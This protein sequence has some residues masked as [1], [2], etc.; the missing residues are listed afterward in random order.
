MNLRTA[1]ALAAL[2]LLAIPMPAQSR[3]VTLLRNVNPG[4][5]FNDVWGYVDPAT[6][7]EYAFLL[8]RAATFIY[9][10]SDPANPILRG[11]IQGSL[12][13]WTASTWRDARTYAGYLYVVTEGGGG[14]QIIDIRNPDQPAFVKTFTLTGWR[15]SHNIAIDVENGVAYPCGAS[16]LGMP[17][18]DIKT[19][20]VNPRLITQYT[21]QYVHDLAIQSGIAHLAEINRGTYHLLDVRQLPTLATLGTHPV[22]SCHNAWP[23]RNDRIA[24]TT[25]ERSNGG[26]T[27]FD[28]S[29]PTAPKLLATYQVGSGT[30]VHNAYVKDQ[31]SHMAYYSEGY[32]VIDLSNPAAPV[33]LGYYDTNACTSGYCGNW[34]CYAF[35]PS[36]VIYASDIT[37]GLFILKPKAS[38]TRY[39]TGTAGT[40]GVTPRA[41]LFG[42][43]WLGNANFALELSHGR[44]NSPAL[45]AVSTKRGNLPIGGLTVWIDLVGSPVLAFPAATD[46]SGNARVPVAVPADLG[47]DGT[48]LRAQAFVADPNGPIGASATEGIEFLMFAK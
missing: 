43:A 39:G 26:V 6:G 44:P 4:G 31:L 7:K 34:G 48:T 28:V 3:N 36:G 19:D 17:I 2:S 13:G 16:G 8:G 27:I 23:S 10:A 30:S 45:F 24:V 20:P 46:G 40:G 22:L 9:D 21:G 18:L 1:T 33:E 32:R 38:A 35:Q 15:N 29:I 37:N 25:S 41:H 42:A 11:T 47:F 14:M 12:S 5:G